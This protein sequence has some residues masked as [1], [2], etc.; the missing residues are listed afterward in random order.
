MFS[1]RGEFMMFCGQALALLPGLPG[2]YLRVCFYFL[3]LK[4]CSLSCSI[5][6]LSCLNDRQAELGQG[7]IIGS[8]VTIGRVSIGARSL[9]GS[10]SSLMSGGRQHQFGPDGRLTSFNR[11]EAQH[12]RVGEDTWIGESSMVMADVGSRCIISAG[13]VVTNAVP[14]RQ[15]WGGNPAR[16]IKRH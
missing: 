2:S 6:F 12:V 1:S 14:D 10:R 8:H 5:G 9:I 3:T 16:F 11:A 4:S 7:V 15:I 13:S